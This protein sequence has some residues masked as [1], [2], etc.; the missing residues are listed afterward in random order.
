MGYKFHNACL[1]QQALTHKSITEKNYMSYERLE[2]LGDAVLELVVSEFL[3]FRF[4]KKS[5]GFLTKTRSSLVNAKTLYE[6]A[7]TLNIAE[8]CIVDKG[9]ELSNSPN[10]TKL[11]SNFVEAIIGAIYLDRGYDK[12]S[13]FIK[14]W[15]IDKNDINAISQFNYKGQ[16]IEYCQKTRK[17]LP[18]FSVESVSG[19]DHERSYTINVIID[20]EIFGS[21]SARTKLGAE[22]EAAEIALKKLQ[23]Q[24]Q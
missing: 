7:V 21:G 6:L 18:K 11:L 3:Y 22:Q 16:L 14:R 12:A 10:Q 8:F 9:L 2:F 1:L 24:F 19:P 15:I 23:S 13:H 4:P 5:E 17:K 20:D